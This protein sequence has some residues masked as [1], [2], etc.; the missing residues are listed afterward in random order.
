MLLLA[1]DCVYMVCSTKDFHELTAPLS[2]IFFYQMKYLLLYLYAYT[3]SL[4]IQTAN[5]RQTI[6]MDYY[7]L[8]RGQVVGDQA[9]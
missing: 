1:S 2:K 8:V 7:R 4:G 6:C 3:F 5:I 9:K